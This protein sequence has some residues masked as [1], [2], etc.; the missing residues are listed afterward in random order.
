MINIYLSFWCNKN[1]NLLHAVPASYF[2]E[3][4]KF[5]NIKA[6]TGNI[7]SIGKNNIKYDCDKVDTLMMFCLPNPVYSKKIIRCNYNKYNLKNSHIKL[8]HASKTKKKITKLIP[9]SINRDQAESPMLQLA[10]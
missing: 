9:F 10:N 5:K 3:N 1:F 4:K 7:F 8:K 6:N 2:S